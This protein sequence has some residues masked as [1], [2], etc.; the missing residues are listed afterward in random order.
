MFH[1]KRRI[2]QVFL[3]VSLVLLIL[4][5]CLWMHS[6]VRMLEFEL[7]L[8]HETSFNILSCY[9]VLTAGRYQNSVLPHSTGLRSG[10]PSDYDEAVMMAR[11]FGIPMQTLREQ[12]SFDY[13]STHLTDSKGRPAAATTV[14]FPHWVLAIIF[15]IPW[16]CLGV[17]R[18]YHRLSKGHQGNNNDQGNLVQQ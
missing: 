12:P 5:V 2:S 17:V 3:V 13:H 10:D 1:V 14:S 9:G 7:A 18:L 6:Y 15:A 11:S 8:D 16:L 4:T